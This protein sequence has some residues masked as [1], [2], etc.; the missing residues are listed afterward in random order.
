[1]FGISSLPIHQLSLPRGKLRHRLLT[2][3]HHSPSWPVVASAIFPPVATAHGTSQP[4]APRPRTT[5]ALAGPGCRTC[6]EAAQPPDFGRML[7]V[8]G[9]WW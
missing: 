8:G 6:P 7:A 1:M 5:A 9:D 2:V 3:H 4:L